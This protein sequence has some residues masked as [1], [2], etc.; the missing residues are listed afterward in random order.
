MGSRFVPLAFLVLFAVTIAAPAPAAYASHQ[1]HT[2]SDSRAPDP[3]KDATVNLYCRLK[4]GK[5]ILSSTGSG[6]FIS[7][8]GVILTN[9]H[10]AQYFLLA[11]EKGRVTGWCSVRTGSPAKETY[12]AEV[13]YLPPA[14]VEEN[15]SLISKNRPKGTGENDFALLYVTGA[16]KKGALPETF[17]ALS[18][19]AVSGATLGSGVTVAGYPSD[20]LDFDDIRNKL[21]VVSATSTVTKLLTFAHQ[22]LIDALAIAPSEA[23]AGGVS[24]GP[25]V[26]SDTEVIGIVTSK[27]SAKEN[28]ALRAISIAYIDRSIT[29][30]VGVSLLELLAEDLAMRAAQSKALI[31]PETIAQLMNELR[32]RK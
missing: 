8:R 18:L 25:V 19:G 2:V 26:N 20:K 22:G 7:E 32:K 24:G 15:I 28:A 14:W 16:K 4:A 17:P 6:V 3:V 11:G 9:A 12:T 31:P 23:G 13:L 29:S 5:K 27:N 21:S 10:V 1:D 30:R